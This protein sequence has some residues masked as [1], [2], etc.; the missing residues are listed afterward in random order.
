MHYQSKV[1][2]VLNLSIVPILRCPIELTNSH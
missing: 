2:L 1:I